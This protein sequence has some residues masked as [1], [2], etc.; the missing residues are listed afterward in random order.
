MVNQIQSF[1]L[2]IFY[3]LKISQVEKFS[4]RF[5]EKIINILDYVYA[6]SLLSLYLH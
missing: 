5:F 1:Y 3:I 6:H 4:D 2:M